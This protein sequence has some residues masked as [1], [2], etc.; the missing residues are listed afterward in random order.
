VANCSD[1]RCSATARSPTSPGAESAGRRSRSPLAI[2]RA[3]S[4]SSMTGRDTLREKRYARISAPTSA[5]NPAVSTSRCAPATMSCIVAAPMRGPANAG[6]G[7]PPHVH[8]AAPRRD[9]AT[10]PDANAVLERLN[11]F[12][13][14]GVILEVLQLLTVELRVAEHHAVTADERDAPLEPL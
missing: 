10:S 14:V 9:A 4:R 7:L 8:L 6:G 5:I 2:A 11:H 3:T 13:A 1:M 12:R